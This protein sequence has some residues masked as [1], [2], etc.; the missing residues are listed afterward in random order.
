M[1]EY[2]KNGSWSPALRTTGS[3]G[4]LQY[5][6]NNKNQFD[7]KVLNGFYPLKTHYSNVPLFHYSMIEAKTHALKNTPYFQLVVEIQKR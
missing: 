2:W 5:W 7:D 4:I 1:M 3:E 6:V